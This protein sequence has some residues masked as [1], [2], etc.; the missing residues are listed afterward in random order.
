[1]KRILIVTLLAAASLACSAQLRG[2][3]GSGP[4]PA[5]G[6]GRPPEP[7]RADAQ[8]AP[9]AGNRDGLPLPEVGRPPEPKASAAGPA[10]ADRARDPQSLPQQIE[11]TDFW[12]LPKVGDYQRSPLHRDAWE[13]ELVTA[14]NKTPQPKQAVTAADGRSVEWREAHVSENQFPDDDLRGGYAATTVTLPQRRVMLLEA[15]GHATAWVNGSPRAGDPYRNGWLRLPIELQPGD[16]NLLFHL[17][18]NRFRARL[19][20]PA[21][22]VLLDLAD[23]TMPDLLSGKA[24]LY[25]ASVVVI[26]A[27][28]ESLQDAKLIAAAAGGAPTTTALPPIPP[29]SVL[30]APFQFE[31]VSSGRQAALQLRLSTGDA[32]LGKVLAEAQ[33]PLGQRT[34]DALHVRTF[35]S[36]VD[37]SVQAYAVLP[38]VGA[39]P[40]ETDADAVPGLIVALHGALRSPRQYLAEMEP[41]SWAH[42]IAPAGRRPHAFDWEDWGR[43][44]ALEAVEDFTQ[45]T[46]VDMQRI[47]LTGHSSGGHGCWHLATVEPDRFAATAPVAGWQSYWTYGGMPKIDKTNAVEEMLQRGTV[48]SDPLK[49]KRNLEGMGVYVLHGADDRRVPAVQ[50]RFMRE[51]L[52]QFHGNFAYRELPGAGNQWSSCRDWPALNAF[53][54]Q[55]A[56]PTQPTKVDFS[57]LHPGISSSAHWLTIEAQQEQL[58]PSRATLQMD[59]ARRHISGRTENVARLT[60]QLDLLVPG[61]K[62]S[63]EIDGQVFDDIQ[64]PEQKHLRLARDDRRWKIGGDTP[65]THKGPQRYG[66]FKQAFGNNALLVYGTRGSEEEK[67]WAFN[68]ARYDAETFYCRGNGSLEMRADVNFRAGSEPHR[69]VVLYGNADTNSAW[70]SLLS[71]SPVQVRRGVVRV[72]LRPESGD[73][74]ACLFVHPRPGSPTALVAVVSGTGMTG[75]RATNRLRYFVPGITYPDFFMV[76]ANYLID[77]N[78]QVRALGYFGLDW[79]LERGEFEWRD[80]A[81]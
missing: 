72:G 32:P 75:L 26:N 29:L 77:G 46:P 10:S 51:E 65:P 63:I 21:Q 74:L 18:G 81:L 80:L 44:D 22:P 6:E 40:S 12:V 3:E 42:V 70:P 79:S 64:W 1:M 59:S 61:E 27:S 68:R 23:A 7:R 62:L 9:T 57:T 48:M 15:S 45:Q 47:Y 56:S 39:G 14:G 69:N 67:A 25:W 17:A 60:L 34:P 24:G 71:T 8:A 5:L 4:L 13:A 20:Q 35:Q 43:R 58:L 50:S 53:L 66:T 33:T 55:Q 37:G 36:D 49:L 31:A 41:K 76:G 19:V 16:N 11:L 38:A 54:R 52:G 30:K 2:A 28:R 78:Q 73:D